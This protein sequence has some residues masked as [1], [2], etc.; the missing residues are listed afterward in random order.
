MTSRGS[1]STHL[2]EL[3]L[4]V[5]A[6]RAEQAVLWLVEHGAPGLE[7]RTVP[8]GVE[9]IL[10]GERREALDR[11]A[12]AVRN[13]FGSSRA[14]RVRVRSAKHALAAWRTAWSQHL[15][16]QRLTPRLV[17]VP[18]TA[19]SPRLA[20]SQRAILLEPVLA[21]GFG[22]H[23]TTRLAVRAVEE[24]CRTGRV[25]RMLDVGTGSGILVFA[26]IFSGAR[27]ASGV[28]IDGDAV[29]A[30]ERNAERNGIA[31]TCRFRVGTASRL[32]GQFDLVVA[33]IR[34]APLLDAATGIAGAVGVGGALILTGVLAE[35]ARELELRYRGL[36]LRPL[37]LRSR[38]RED[39]W[40]LVAL[41]RPR[42][43]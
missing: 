3:A 42:L 13:A 37:R 24:V 33:N 15:A 25:E 31:S 18:T 8:N 35:E 30:A 16:P 5:S 39:G 41:R 22:E 43:R 26:G 28:D 14:V 40:A 4:R 29:A 23:P 17:A 9:V 12:R 1:S 2:Y 38:R 32:R 20:S 6:E 7:E 36:G 11:L 34:L 19:R 27:R 10:Y 21:F